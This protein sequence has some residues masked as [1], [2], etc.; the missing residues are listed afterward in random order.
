[1]QVSGQNEGSQVYTSMCSLL[2][3]MAG[4]SVY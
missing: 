4:H 3:S 2:S 1:M